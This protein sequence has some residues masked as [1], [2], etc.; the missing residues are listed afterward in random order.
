MPTVYEPVGRVRVNETLSI[1]LVNTHLKIWFEDMSTYQT[2]GF[3]SKMLTY[4]YT[5]RSLKYQ[6][7]W[8]SVAEQVPWRGTERTRG[9]RVKR[10]NTNFIGNILN[11]IA[12][13]ATEDQLD[14]IV[15]LDQDMRRQMVESMRIASVYR[16][17]VAKGA[18]HVLF[19]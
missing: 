13:V 9:A 16:E 3:Q 6:Y 4:A 5:S 18:Y 2:S 14:R 1:S 19:F 11:S 17:D 7:L 15:S 8:K 12:G 10:S